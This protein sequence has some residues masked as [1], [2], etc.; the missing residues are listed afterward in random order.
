MN[1]K[2]E[3]VF[4]WAAAV[5]LFLTAAAEL[6]ST[7]ND[8]QFLNQSDPLLFISSR[9][10][11]ALT[12]VFEL[13]ISGFLLMGQ[14]KWLKLGLAAWLATDLLV[15]R[16]G[17]QWTDAPNYSD[18]LGNFNDWLPIPPRILHMIMVL[19]LGFLIV[20]SYALLILGWLNNRKSVETRSVMV[21]ALKST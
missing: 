14:N 13:L 7:V 18:C 19:I 5:I 15:Y 20:G 16:I 2:I 10:V 8:A 21:D 3:A 9:R 12:G 11:L 4:F 17:L 1:R 6:S